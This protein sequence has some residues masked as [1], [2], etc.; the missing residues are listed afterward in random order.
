MET[1]RDGTIALTTGEILMQING[2]AHLHGPQSI[3]APHAS[4]QA[5]PASPTQAVRESDELD[6]SPEA[7]LIS[8]IRDLPD[9]RAD[10]V[11]SIRAEIESGA[12]E[13]DAKLDVALDRLLDEI[14]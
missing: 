4:K 7:D 11:A 2:P 9:I 14:G 3:N 6:I 8:R 12:Y 10:R 1:G 5:E 13:T